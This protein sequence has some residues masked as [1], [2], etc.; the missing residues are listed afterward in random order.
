MKKIIFSLFVLPLFLLGYSANLN[1]QSSEKELDQA[2]LMKQFTGTWT[3]EVGEDSTWTWAVIPFGEGYETNA[4]F[5]VKGETKG[6]W[7]GV[8]GFQEARKSV[9]ICQMTLRGGIIRDVGKF[10]SDTKMVFDRYLARNP[11]RVRIKAEIEIITPDKY[12]VTFKNR[13]NNE[14]WD[15]AEVSEFIYTRVNK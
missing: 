4:K 8:M 11:D 13:G 1:A 7:K 10:V 3:S 2:E 9:V 5:Q 12:K 6:S 15:G 14:T